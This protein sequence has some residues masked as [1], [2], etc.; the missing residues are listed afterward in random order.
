M[1]A[2]FNLTLGQ[3]CDSPFECIPVPN[4]P[5]SMS[6][7]LPNTDGIPSKGGGT[8]GSRTQQVFKDLSNLTIYAL[9]MHIL[10]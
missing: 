4:I 9:Y 8:G 3:L 6:I 10:N 1:Y 2:R 5:Y 7:A